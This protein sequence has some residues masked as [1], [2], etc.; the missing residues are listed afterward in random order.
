MDIAHIEYAAEMF[1]RMCRAHPEV[2][3]H[4][5]YWSGTTVDKANNVE[6]KKYICELCGKELKERIELSE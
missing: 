4:D 2:C 1:F 6:I 3:P 5:Y